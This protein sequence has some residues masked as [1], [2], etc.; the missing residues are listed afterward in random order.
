M[1][2]L[3]N[4]IDLGYLLKCAREDKDLSQVKVMEQ[5]GINNKTLSGYENNVAEPDFNTL[6]KLLRLYEHSL[7]Y[8][9]FPQSSNI[10]QN[11]DDFFSVFNDLPQNVKDDVKV[12]INA[13]Y[14]KYK[15]EKKP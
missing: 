15:K 13:L 2:N 5:T 4:N 11:N 9:I 14:K 7:D 8:L 10:K 12:Q 6:I 1:D 3:F